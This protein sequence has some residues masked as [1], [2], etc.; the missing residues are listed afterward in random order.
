[1]EFIG[2]DWIKSNK[3]EDDLGGRPGGITQVWFVV[4]D[5]LIFYFAK[6]Q[7]TV[8][9]EDKRPFPIHMLQIV[10]Q[11]YVYIPHESSIWQKYAAE[12]GPEFFFIINIQVILLP[13][14]CF[15]FLLWYIELYI[16][17]QYTFN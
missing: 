8:Y 13:V 17:I 9:R 1:M 14:L 4:W 7:C 3:R 10:M 15:C 11:L 6:R 2:A 5:V 16:L 12:G